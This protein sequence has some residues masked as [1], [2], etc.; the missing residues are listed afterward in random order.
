MPAELIVVFDVNVL[1]P[2]ILP[3]SRSTRLLERLTTLGHRVALTPS[4][5]ADVSDKL[6]NKASLRK[7][8]G[9]DD[10]KIEQFIDA[11]RALC[12]V[13]PGV[14]S[15]HAAVLA[16]PDDDEILAAAVESGATYVI[17]EDRH[18]LDLGTW[19]GIRILTRDELMEELDRITGAEGRP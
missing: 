6:R 16:D 5:L 7:W 9:V 15:V 3:K 12:L 1:I 10:K 8:L 13:F 14:V 17:S 18:L 19:Q 11:L 4:I 2:L